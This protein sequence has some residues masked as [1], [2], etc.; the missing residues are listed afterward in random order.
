MKRKSIIALMLCTI[1]I[2]LLFPITVS[3]DTGP[4]P[5]VIINFENIEDELCYGTLLSKKESTG[6][7]SVWNGNDDDAR[8]NENPKYS[9]YTFDYAT[10]KAFAE[11]EDTD[12]YYF[13]QLGWNVSENN[14]IDWTYYPPNTFKILLYYP[15]TQTFVVSG[16]YEKYAFDSYYTVD[17]NGINISSVDYNEKLST[18]ER[19]E[20]YR[21][22]LE[23]YRSYKYKQEIIALILRIVITILIETVIAL[24]FGFRK[25][26]QILLL[27]GVNT[28]TQILL[29]LVLNV[30]AYYSVEWVFLYILL[31]IVIF[32]LEAVLY[33]KWMKKLSDKPRKNRYYI[34]YSL[35]ANAVSFGAGILISK[36][37][38]LPD[39]L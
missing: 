5:S 38:W 34:L 35:I 12:G 9:N 28:L 25:K 19:I 23:A 7:F 15:E 31:E 14:K 22:N 30:T 24:F 29:N 32:A 27:I 6:P 4:K 17:M 21:A 13:L 36:C 33:C 10:W 18:D 26:K 8:H 2:I 39:I 11:Y 3:A 20:E 16:I 1:L 37:F